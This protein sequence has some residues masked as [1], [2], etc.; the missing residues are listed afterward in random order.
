MCEI[1][2]DFGLSIFVFTLVQKE[3]KQLTK[4]HFDI[5]LN[6]WGK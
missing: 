6:I 1:S 4:Q 3:L 5:K 2:T